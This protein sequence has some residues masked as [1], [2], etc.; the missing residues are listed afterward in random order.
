MIS[1]NNRLINRKNCWL[2]WS[3]LKLFSIMILLV[4]YFTLFS[5]SILSW[6]RSSPKHNRAGKSQATWCNYMYRVQKAKHEEWT[7]RRTHG[8]LNLE[9]SDAQ[10]GFGPNRFCPVELTVTQTCEWLYLPLVRAS[11]PQSHFS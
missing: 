9:Q 6:R 4:F 2:W 10:I 11:L 7:D 1:G 3:I 5:I 8:I